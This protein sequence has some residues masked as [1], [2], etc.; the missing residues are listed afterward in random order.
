MIPDG[1]LIALTADGVGLVIDATGGRLPAIVHWGAA[2]G[3]MT[4]EQA[5]ALA[6]AAVPVIG[7]NNADVP[8]RLTLLPEHHTGWPGRPGLTGSRA[9]RQW[10]PAFTVTE[11]L[12]D[13]EPVTGYVTAGAASVEFRAVDEAAGLGLTLVVALLPSGLLRARAAVTNLAEEPY[14]LDVLTLALPVPADA[15]EL[16]DFAGRHNQERVPQ[17][18][19]FRT[20]L[21]LRENRRG[22]T[23]AD[24]AYV[25]H[26]GPAGFGFAAGRVH[27]VCTA[28]T[29][30]RAKP[31]PAAPACSTYAVSGPVRPRR[32]SRRCS[33]VWKVLRCGT[34]SW[35]CL[36]AKSSSSSASAGTGSARVRASSA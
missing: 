15:D 8:P 12:V 28:C 19:A 32:F 6:T 17:R 10:S 20:G 35:L 7:S 2:L 34:R 31:N 23:G 36:P 3:P 21:H 13:G 30:P 22:R 33:P 24:S 18:T 26:A 27:A 5:A 1:D 14:A 4:A 16:L 25:L 9:G 11:I 29:S